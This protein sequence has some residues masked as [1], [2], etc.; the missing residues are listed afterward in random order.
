MFCCRHCSMLSTILVGT[1]TPDCGLTMLSNVDNNV[2]NK[3]VFNIAM[4]FSSTQNKLPIFGYVY[5]EKII[6]Y[7]LNPSVGTV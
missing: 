6:V 2:G 7:Y 1:V 5:L 3:T 4:L